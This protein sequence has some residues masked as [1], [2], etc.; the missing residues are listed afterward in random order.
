MKYKIRRNVTADNPIWDEDA[1]LFEKMSKEATSPKEREFFDVQHY[2]QV[3]NFTCANDLVMSERNNP[4]CL[5]IAR[6]NSDEY[7]IGVEG[8]GKEVHTMNLSE[9]L[10]INLKTAGLLNRDITLLDWL[11]ERDYQGVEYE[12]NF[13]DV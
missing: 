4:D 9:A 1:R 10:S 7:I 13:D 11:R 12:H 6:V 3:N 5:Y 8:H 2:K